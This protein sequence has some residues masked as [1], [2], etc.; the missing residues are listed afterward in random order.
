MDGGVEGGLWQRARI[1]KA[2]NPRFQHGNVLDYAAGEG[3][4]WGMGLHSI[5]GGYTR[6]PV[7]YWSDDD[8]ATWQ[9]PELL[10]GPMRPGTD[11]GYGDLKRRVDG[12]FVAVAYYATRDSKV[13]DLEQ[14]TFGGRR[15]R[16]RL[17]GGRRR[18][19]GRGI[20]LAGDPRRRRELRRPVDGG[21]LAIGPAA[22]QRRRGSRTRN[23]V[24]PNRAVAGMMPTLRLVR[25]GMSR[26]EF[27]LAGVAG[28]A[29]NSSFPFQD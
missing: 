1:Y 28:A 25:N 2:S 19:G 26:I 4:L 14:Y 11:T 20:E 29:A 24:D 8:G 18:P 3:R 7:V 22:V 5:G 9:G 6:K 13:S 10:H 23:Q 12:T 21:W 15:A 27:S 17:E 16:F